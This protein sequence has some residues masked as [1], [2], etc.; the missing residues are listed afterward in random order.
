MLFGVIPGT[1]IVIAPVD[2]MA[3]IA[4]AITT[5][6]LRITLW[7]RIR[8]FFTTTLP[9]PVSSRQKRSSHTAA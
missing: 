3:A 4:T 5:I 7:S 8:A 6:I 9:A 2:M 1:D